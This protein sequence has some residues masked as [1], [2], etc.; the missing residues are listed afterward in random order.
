VKQIV[1]AH[2]GRV[3][4]ESEPGRGSEFVVW[5]PLTT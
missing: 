4:L 3:S 1:N 2:R 5:L